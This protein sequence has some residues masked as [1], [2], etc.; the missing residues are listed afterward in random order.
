MSRILSSRFLFQIF[1][2]ILSLFIPFLASEKVLAQ[3]V[4]IRCSDNFQKY[5][6]SVNLPEEVRLG[7]AF[8]VK[9]AFTSIADTS[10]N[11]Y[12]KFTQPGTPLFGQNIG[13]ADF[14]T[15]WQH[16][17]NPANPEIDFSFDNRNDTSPGTFQ[18]SLMYTTRNFDREEEVCKLGTINF[19]E[20]NMNEITCNL[21]MPDKV[22]QDKPFT[23]NLD[24]VDKPNIEYAFY[25]FS[26]GDIDINKLP[27]GMAVVQTGRNLA[28]ISKFTPGKNT[29]YSSGALPSNPS[30]SIPITYSNNG[31]DRL[32]GGEYIAVIEARRLLNWNP[33]F[34][35]TG[36]DN[37]WLVSYCSYH[38]FTVSSEPTSAETDGTAIAKPGKGGTLG[39]EDLKTET[40][41]ERLRKDPTAKCAEAG[42]KQISGCGGQDDPRGPAIATAIGC[43]HTNPVEFTKDIMKFVL[44]IAGG[45]A[46]LMM[47]M[48][49]FQIL[50]S[51]DNPDTLKAGRE[52]LT[53]AVIGLLLVI[54]AVLL[55]QI[56]GIDILHLPG[57]GRS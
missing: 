55:L 48:G 47:L 41:L 35:L 27:K 34:T 42:G 24:K 20:K 9:V 29:R 49:A 52:R 38:P 44:G 3:N 36:D 28:P 10:L 7:E 5:I 57:F 21:K 17:S 15:E 22:E 19:V 37:K 30:G 56:I 25:F 32:R 12:L 33:S 6:R 16:I 54:F 31:G 40:C 43:I 51:A 4:N 18:L 39:G 45:L 11:Y 50:S 53:S 13:N 2:V 8:N 1:S 26:K 14:R 23:M 46:F